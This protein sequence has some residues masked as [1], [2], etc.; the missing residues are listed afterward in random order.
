MN[1]RVAKHHIFLIQKKKKIIFFT[2]ICPYTLIELVYL[3]ETPQD[4]IEWTTSKGQTMDGYT[5]PPSRHKVNRDM[6]QLE[7]KPKTFGFI[8]CPKSKH[9]SLPMG[10]L[11][12]GLH[13]C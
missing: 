8:V 2:H 11:C 12:R 4:I 6:P 3:F 1:E 13:F 10:T 5:F 7:I 9:F